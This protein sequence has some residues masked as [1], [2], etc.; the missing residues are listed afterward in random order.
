MRLRP[1]EILTALRVIGCGL[2]AT[3]SGGESARLG[4]E[5]TDA[6][7]AAK[8]GGS[9][10]PVI[11]EVCMST[12]TKMPGGNRII[13]GGM[14]R[15][16]AITRVAALVT[17]ATIVLT[18]LLSAGPAVAAKTR[19]NWMREFVQLRQLALAERLLGPEAAA[20]LRSRMATRIVGGTVAAPTTHPFQVGLL[21]KQEQDN[22]FAQ[23]CGGSLIRP[24]VV[25]T[26]AHCSD[27]VHRRDV[28]VLTGTQRLD[29][30]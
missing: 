3:S 1:R 6:A 9:Q 19:H 7:E 24:D 17:A 29:G 8:I 11:L 14:R 28:Q 30:S 2:S 20:E 25:V 26:A 22:F 5:K 21:F 10:S 18:A 12:T 15:E 16:E 13:P 23:Y 4:C 27:F